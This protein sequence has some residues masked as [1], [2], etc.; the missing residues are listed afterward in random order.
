MKN[1]KR[2]FAAAALTG[3]IILTTTAAN[4]GII[5]TDGVVSTN[6]CQENNAVTSTLDSILSATG[7]SNPG[8]LCGMLMAD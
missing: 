6:P 5:I 1:I 4:A 3:I 2:T 8:T 7:I